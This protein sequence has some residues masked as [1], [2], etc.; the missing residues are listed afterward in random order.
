MKNGILVLLRPFVCDQKFYIFKE[1]E[2]TLEGYL[3]YDDNFPTEIVEIAYANNLD[4]INI[5]GPYNYAIK[6]HGDIIHYNNSKFNE[7]PLK[8]NILSMKS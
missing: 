2:V 7:K 4:M 3:P 6:T 1:G 8:V 5:S